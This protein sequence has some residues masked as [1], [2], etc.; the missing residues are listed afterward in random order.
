MIRAMLAV[1]RAHVA[2]PLGMVSI[3][4]GLLV[5][6]SQFGADSIPEPTTVYVPGPTVY[7]L[8]PPGMCPEEDS[9]SV[10]WTGTEWVVV[11]NPEAS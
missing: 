1:M 6:V 9:C 7:V 3:V 11:P 5:I 4:V 2:I 10:D 8:T